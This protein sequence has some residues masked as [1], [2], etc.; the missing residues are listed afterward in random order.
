[1]QSDEQVFIPA[2]AEN[3]L[4]TIT[5]CFLRILKGHRQPLSEKASL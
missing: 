2:F 5:S 1:M 3:P 4:Q